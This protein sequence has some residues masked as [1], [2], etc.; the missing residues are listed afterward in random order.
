MDS[1]AVVHP[2]GVHPAE[3][4]QP[5]AA[6]TD[7]LLRLA[8]QQGAPIEMLERLLDLHER[9]MARSA[10]EE[11]V[12]ALAAFQAQV[13][14]VPRT[15]R[16]DITTKSGARY[17]Y[18]YAPLDVIAEHIR[19]PLASHGLSYTWEVQPAGD[20]AV[21]VTCVVRHVAGHEERASVIVPVDS[22]ARMSDAQAYGAALT[23]GRRQSLVSALGL[24]SA[25]EDTD[26]ATARHQ[27]GTITPEQALDLEALIQETG[28]DRARFLA[29]LGVS[30]LEDITLADLPRAIKALEAKRRGG[31]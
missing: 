21:Q 1:H 15:A 2:Q 7:T 27:A 3:S 20:R 5:S 25:D 9:I 29:W 24:T 16:A 23:Y 17:G 10:R 14:P 12:A 30:R 4:P 19:G 26:G 13:G 6:Q 22:A 11:F 18:S 31:R 8:I 28:T